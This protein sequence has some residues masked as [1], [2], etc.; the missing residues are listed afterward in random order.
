MCDITS[1][2]LA[3]QQ[4][5]RDKLEEK[6]NGL[7]FCVRFAPCDMYFATCLASA[8]A[9]V[10][11]GTQEATSEKIKQKIIAY[12][13]FWSACFNLRSHCTSEQ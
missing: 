8:V 10:S 5:M 1:L 3:T 7:S 12:W 9:S 4:K 6:L 13:L 11:L 2:Q